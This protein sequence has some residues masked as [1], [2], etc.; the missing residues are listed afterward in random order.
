MY[1]NQFSSELSSNNS[2][3]TKSSFLVKPCFEGRPYPCYQ[4]GFRDTTT[5]SVRVIRLEDMRLGIE[6]HTE[7]EFYDLKG[8]QPVFFLMETLSPEGTYQWNGHILF[9]HVNKEVS[10]RLVEQHQKE[11]NIVLSFSDPDTDR[12]FFVVDTQSEELTEEAFLK[13]R[14]EWAERLNKTMSHVTQHNMNFYVRALTPEYYD[15]VDLDA[16]FGKPEPL[17]Q[18]DDFRTCRPM[19]VGEIIQTFFGRIFNF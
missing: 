19:S 3:R 7:E 10:R 12:Y 8:K 9:S 4:S 11:W 18:Q 16:L 2:I 5:E 17:H 13:A 14:K 15:I 6:D 1:K